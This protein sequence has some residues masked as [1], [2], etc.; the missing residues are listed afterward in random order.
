LGV[1]NPKRP[2]GPGFVPWTKEDVAAYG[3]R[4]LIGTCERVWL[5]VLLYTGLRRG[6]A[7]RLGRR[8]SA[9]LKT[10]KSQVHR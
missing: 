3:K 7:V 6:D 9:T 2:N 4:W 8:D 10:E 5:D 1:S